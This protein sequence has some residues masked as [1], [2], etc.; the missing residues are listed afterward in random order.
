M[1]DGKIID[2]WVTISDD[3]KTIGGELHIMFQI[4]TIGWKPFDITSIIPLKKI[5]FW[6]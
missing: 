4:C 5:R 1:G 2:K 6:F 3:K